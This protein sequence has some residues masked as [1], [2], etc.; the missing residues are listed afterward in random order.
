M[1][2]SIDQR[3]VIQTYVAWK[4]TNTRVEAVWPVG[5]LSKKRGHWMTAVEEKTSFNSSEI[6][7]VSPEKKTVHG[8]S[9]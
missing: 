8:V 4:N 9:E 5:R 1:I 2:G 7:V 3:V 6:C